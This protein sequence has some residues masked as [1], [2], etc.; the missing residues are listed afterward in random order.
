MSFESKIENDR[1]SLTNLT[2]ERPIQ[3]TLMVAPLPYGAFAFDAETLEGDRFTYLGY[4]GSPV[5]PCRA[6]SGFY[7]P[8][9]KAI[10]V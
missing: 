6:L 2:H 9:R 7:F 10:E 3:I 4:V 1:S 5:P 8:Q